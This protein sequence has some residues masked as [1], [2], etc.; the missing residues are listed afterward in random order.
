MAGRSGR[1]RQGY[2][3]RA[4]WLRAHRRMGVGPARRLLCNR[5]IALYKCGVQFDM[6]CIDA[7]R[8]ADALKVHLHS[9]AQ[10]GGAGSNA[11]SSSSS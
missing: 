3:P 9:D 11:R 6:A 4:R 1:V 2:K 8:A 5:A 7:M 10:P